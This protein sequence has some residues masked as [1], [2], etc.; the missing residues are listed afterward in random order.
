MLQVWVSYGEKTS[1]ELLLS[2]GFLPEAGANP[3][4]ACLLRM[5]L[6]TAER[7]G[8]GWKQASRPPPTWRWA[9]ALGMH[10]WLP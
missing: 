4:D 10:G 7:P 6:Q 2:Y 1:G 9:Q 5:R 3:H 8:Q